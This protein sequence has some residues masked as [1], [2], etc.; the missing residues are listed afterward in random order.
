MSHL[1]AG[2]PRRCHAHGEGYPPRWGRVYGGTVRGLQRLRSDVWWE[3]EQMRGNS[4]P[5]VAVES[6]DLERG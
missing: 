4:H 3:E 1:S 6:G 2:R 5:R